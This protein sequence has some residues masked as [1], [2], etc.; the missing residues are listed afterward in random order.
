MTAGCRVG[1][2]YLVGKGSDDLV[3]ARGEFGGDAAVRGGE[4]GQISSRPSAI[5]FLSLTFFAA[6]QM[7]D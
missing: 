3:A 2:E 5:G 7:L 4:R 6:N 1:Y